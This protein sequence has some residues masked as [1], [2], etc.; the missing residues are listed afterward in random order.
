MTQPIS[1]PKVPQA[2]LSHLEGPTHEVHELSEFL[3]IGRD[4]NNQFQVNDPSV[5][6]RHARIEWRN[7]IYVLKD[8]RSR[9]GTLVNGAQI[10]EAPLSHN[11]RIRIGNSELIFRTERDKRPLSLLLTSKNTSW[12]SK[13]RSLPNFSRSDLA[14]LIGGP[15]GT[16]KEILAQMIHRYSARRE[17]PFVSVNCSAMSESLAESELF[18]HTK[19]SFTDATH[20]RKGAFESAHAG[21]LFLDEIGDLPLSLQPKLLRYLENREIRPVGAD[22][23]ITTDVRIVAATH[24]NLKERVIQGEFRADLYFRLNILNIKAPALRNRMEDFENL[25]HH[26]AREYKVAFSTE[27]IDRLKEHRWPGNI[28]ELKN[29][30][31]RAKTLCQDRVMASDLESLIDILPEDFGVSLSKI[32]PLGPE[33][34]SGNVIKDLERALIERRLQINNGNQRKTAADLGLPKSTL[35]DRIKTYQID[36]RSLTSGDANN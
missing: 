24:H 2:F 25:L 14:I 35:H 22:R 30:V 12:N 5:S 4:D 27:A 8:L 18:G 16:G 26:F 28:R 34:L 1:R 23:T 7:G 36:L 13:L 10:L 6:S 19:K 3:T 29:V 15:S 31:A 20:D 21:T 33:P 32:S 17:G 9:H 11:D